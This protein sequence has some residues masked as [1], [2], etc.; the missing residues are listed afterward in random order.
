[1]LELIDVVYGFA[2]R[3]DFLGPVNLSVQPGECWAV[4][5]PNGA[6]KSTLMRLMA[7]LA[8]PRA[9]RIELQ[10]RPLSEYSRRARAQRIALVPQRGDSTF[11]LSVREIVL[12]GRYPHRL[13]G[14]FDSPDD[15]RI[16]ERVMTQTVTR[17]FADRPL[18]T[19]SGGEAARAHLAA[20]LAQQPRVLLL[21]EPTA[22]LD[23]RHERD[24]FEL[25]R[26]HAARERVAVVVVTHDVNLAADFCSH[27]LVLDDGKAVAAGLPG[28]VL[29]PEVLAPVYEVALASVP[30]PDDR[31]RKWLIPRQPRSGGPP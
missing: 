5:G 20:A 16:A 25:L 2:T 19:L 30:D 24:V 12:L 8:V 3:P 1:V 27:V 14:L 9:G 17:E 15:E 26:T 11:D 31:G 18:A 4:V 7:G 21:D 10:G 28:E 29:R 6:G 13:L 23:L 22:S